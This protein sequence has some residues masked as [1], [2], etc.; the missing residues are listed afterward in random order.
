MSV[1]QRDGRYMVYYKEDGKRR[2]K[3][4]GRGEAARQQAEAFDQAVRQAKEQGATLPDPSGFIVE[5]SGQQQ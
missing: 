4:F 3:S 2:D 5:S 1:Y